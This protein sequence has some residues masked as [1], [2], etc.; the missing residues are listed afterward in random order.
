MPT[1]LAVI[2]KSRRQKTGGVGVLTKSRLNLF[3]ATFMAGSRREPVFLYV[4]VLLMMEKSY[5]CESHYHS[6][7]V[8]G[9]DYIVITDASAW[10][11]DYR[12]A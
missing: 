4:Q 5:A 9:F 8:A 3:T 6:V 2:K 11:S 7:L 1:S 12:N 10:L